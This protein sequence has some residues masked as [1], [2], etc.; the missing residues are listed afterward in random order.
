MSE[1]ET[2]TSTESRRKIKPRKERTT[3]KS[4]LWD[5]VKSIG[6]AVVVV[7]FLHYFVFNLS[8]VEGHS[9]QPT[10]LEKEW[11][12]VDK[13]VYWIGDPERGDVVILKDPSEGPDKKD[14]LV[15][16]I[17]GLPGDTVEVRDS[18][19]YVNGALEIEP[20]TDTEIADGDVGPV[21]VEAGHYFVMG[22][23]R[24]AS[25]SKDSRIFGT[26]SKDM[27][28]GR[29]DFILWPITKIKGL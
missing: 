2:N 14:F 18:K 16:R 20:Y 4:E 13:I 3:F 28:K 17:I 29:A 10:L 11:L 22:D 25:A 19:L 21:V 27:I 7:L 15:K 8:K 26:V 6:I 9:M 1:L 5:W 12:F 24:H 23:N